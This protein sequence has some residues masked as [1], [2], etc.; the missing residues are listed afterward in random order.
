M[1]GEINDLGASEPGPLSN[2]TPQFVAYQTG[3]QALMRL[4]PAVPQRKWMDATRYR[5]A[6]RCLPMV[7]ANQ[8]G[9][10][11]VNLHR[12][13]AVWEGGEEKSSLKIG[14]IRGDSIMAATSHFGHGIMTWQLPWLFRT[15]PGFNLLIRGPANFPKDAASPLE[16][17]VEADWSVSSATMNWQITR[18]DT[19]VVFEKDEPIAMLV[20]QRRHEL[21]S[22]DPAE[23]SL[24]SDPA[25]E[26]QFRAWSTS[27]DS[28]LRDLKMPGTEAS[29][30]GWQKDYT[31]G[32]DTR[33]KRA[34][35]HQT[36]IILRDFKPK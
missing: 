11:V 13:T 2:L 4:I 26:E 5:F 23:R 10:W 14:P 36:R 27:R 9:W 33:G 12:V 3:S 21:E 19:E 24:A 25:L 18:K 35:E 34:P 32:T 28:F 1:S 22:F 30:S 7:I 15:P 31:R 20:P 17:V 8:W 29:N 16:G 6:Y